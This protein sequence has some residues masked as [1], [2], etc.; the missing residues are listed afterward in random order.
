MYGKSSDLGCSSGNRI[1]RHD[2]F[3][4]TEVHY[5]AILADTGPGD[6]FGP[7]IFNIFKYDFFKQ[8]AVE[9]SGL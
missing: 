1:R 7:F 9:F 2:A 8:F 3:I 6:D 5:G 4:G